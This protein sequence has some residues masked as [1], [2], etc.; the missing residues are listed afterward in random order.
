MKKVSQ[1]ISPLWWY[2]TFSQNKLC[3]GERERERERAVERELSRESFFSTVIFGQVHRYTHIIY[4][5]I[6]LKMGNEISIDILSKT[7]GVD[8]DLISTLGYAFDDAWDDDEDDD[9]IEEEASVETLNRVRL[10]WVQHVRKCMHE[11]SFSRKYRMSHKAF[12]KLVQILDPCLHRNSRNAT[13]GQFIIPQIVVAIGIRYLAGEP[14]TALNDIANISTTSVYR[15]RNRFIAALLKVDAMKI[16]IPDSA[17]EWEA[18]RRGF[19][20]ISCDKLFRGCVGAIDGFFAPIQQPRVEDAN[21]NPMSFMSGHYGMFGLNCQAVCDARERFLFFGVVAPGKTNDVI[22][23]EYCSHLKEVIANL[24]YGLFLVGDAAYTCTERMLTPMTGSQRLDPVNDAYNFYLSQ[25]RIRIEMAF[26]RLVTKWRILRAPLLGSLATI[27]RTLMACAIMHN[28][29]IEVDGHND[30]LSLKNDSVGNDFEFIVT[31]A[32]RGMT[33]LPTMPDFD[34]ESFL[35]GSPL[36]TS[37]TVQ[38]SILQVIDQLCIRRP[39]AN[40]ERNGFGKG[41]AQEAGIDD[42]FYAPS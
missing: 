29:V 41:R 20:N 24:P 11:K 42:A 9:L 33:Y 25:V 5:H 2:E 38:A 31:N 35:G 16:K 3:K 8:R 28:Y 26:A 14:Y 37:H 40:I 18:V 22:A 12:C 34:E 32:P 19:E 7:W 15:L 39:R 13:R 23:F 6:I 27:S 21:G 1:T 4:K 36:V 10:D 17:E 30:H